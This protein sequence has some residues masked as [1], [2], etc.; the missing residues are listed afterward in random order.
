MGYLYGLQE[1]NL[2]QMVWG[3][4]NSY[5]S[6]YL[7]LDMQGTPLTRHDEH[8]TNYYAWLRS[9]FFP[10]HQPPNPLQKENLTS[11]NSLQK[12]NKLATLLLTNS[13]H[14]LP[15]NYIPS[16]VL[17]YFPPRLMLGVTIKG[18]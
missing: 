15:K 13:P 12:K 3:K 5:C 14:G 16:F 18:V 4:L 8:A 6:C 17:Y 1:Y 9:I 10:P 11:H 7:F 2:G